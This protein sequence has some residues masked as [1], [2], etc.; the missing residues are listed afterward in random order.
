MK[1]TVLFI[2]TLMMAGSLFAY[3]P[4][5]EC[6]TINEFGDLVY[7]E[8]DKHFSIRKKDVKKYVESPFFEQELTLLDLQRSLYKHSLENADEVLKDAVDSYPFVTEENF[9]T[10]TENEMIKKYKKFVK[11]V[12]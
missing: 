10:I 5:V 6:A 3:E 8:G 7:E 9:L 2:M 4:K 12:K 1:K 11:K